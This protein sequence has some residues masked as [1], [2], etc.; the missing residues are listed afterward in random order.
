MGEKKF[1]N[2]TMNVATNLLTDYEIYSKLIILKYCRKKC[3][4]VLI[5]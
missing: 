1:W 2:S 4:V 3:V 5:L